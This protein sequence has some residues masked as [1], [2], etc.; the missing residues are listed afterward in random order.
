M[1]LTTRDMQQIKEVVTEVVDKSIASAIEPLASK[2]DLRGFA[3]KDDLLQFAT[4]DD[5]A[6]TNTLITSIKT[7][8]EEDIFAEAER[9]DKIDRRLTKVERRLDSISPTS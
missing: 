7:M 8:L 3:T 1:S 9:V 5:L 6:E 4:K 2:D